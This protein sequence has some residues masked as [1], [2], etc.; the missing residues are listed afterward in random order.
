M[1]VSCNVPSEVA[2]KDLTRRVSQ[3][4]LI[5]VITE[6]LISTTYNG[7]SKVVAEMPKIARLV[8]YFNYVL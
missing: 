2:S 7:R 8:G 6:G 3:L 1:K 4:G 5:P